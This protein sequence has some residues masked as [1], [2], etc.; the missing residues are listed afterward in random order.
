MANVLD[1]VRG[2]EQQPS[3][4]T[5]FANYAAKEMFGIILPQARR[6]F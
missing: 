4:L 5:S 1:I 6:I 3:T 2:N